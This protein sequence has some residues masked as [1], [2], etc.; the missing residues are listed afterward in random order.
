MKN[1]EGQS[2][3]FL[4]QR[5]CSQRHDQKGGG[6]ARAFNDAK[7]QQMDDARIKKVIL[8]GMS[9]SGM[10]SFMDEVSLPLTEDPIDSLVPYIRNLVPH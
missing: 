3:I 4:Y 8:E 2:G 5:A 7:W 6:S 1:G 9:E 10:P